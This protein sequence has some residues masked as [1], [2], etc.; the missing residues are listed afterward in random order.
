MNDD[1][2]EKRSAEARAMAKTPVAKAFVEMALA[3][4]RAARAIGERSA[5]QERRS[6]SHALVTPEDLA[7]LDKL[8]EAMDGELARLQ[9]LD[10]LDRI[11]VALGW[12]RPRSVR[13]LSK[14]YGVE[15][16]RMK[17]EREAREAARLAV[18]ETLA[19][20][21]F[22]IGHTVEHVDGRV[23]VVRDI[24]AIWYGP[25]G[26]RQAVSPH[27]PGDGEQTWYPQSECRHACGGGDWRK[28]N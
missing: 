11:G 24:K 26:V 19:P 17:A 22:G 27:E 28:V 20:S 5:P 23:F 18:D 21:R 2:W 15:R 6:M 1:E 12:D 9:V 13:A 16:E 4:G 8:N 25:R 3:L 7:A 10:A 14:W